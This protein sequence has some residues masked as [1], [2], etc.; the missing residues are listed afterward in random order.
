[1]AAAPVF[2]AEN[3]ADH[4]AA[5]I[6]RVEVRR[7]VIDAREPEK[8]F[9]LAPVPEASRQF[10]QGMEAARS[11]WPAP[12]DEKL[13]AACERA[14]ARLGRAW[15]DAARQGDAATLRAYLEE[16]FPIFYQDRRN[17][18]TAL[19]AAAGSQA[20]PAL[21]V[22][23]PRWPDFLMRDRRGRLASELAYLYGEDPAMARFLGSKER[24]DAIAT[25]RDVR[26]RI[27]AYRAR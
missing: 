27:Y 23:V 21:R 16:G 19:H 13:A 15:L 26:R 11:V 8:R 6:E 1:V 20:R 2:T 14:L 25:G 17:G 24:K 9:T 22:L 5:F 7:R 18:E 3:L 4:L 12:V 10:W